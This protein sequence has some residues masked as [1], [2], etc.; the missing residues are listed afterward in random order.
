VRASRPLPCLLSAALVSLVLGAWPSPVY[1]Q[2]A[3]QGLSA[4][5]P[6]DAQAPFRQ[7]VRLDVLD[8]LGGPMDP[9]PIATTTRET[10][11]VPPDETDRFRPAVEAALEALS[12]HA[13]TQLQTFEHDVF[14]ELSQQ[15]GL[16]RSLLGTGQS[17]ALPAAWDL[18]AGR[19]FVVTLPL[20]SHVDTSCASPGNTCR[21]AFET[22]REVLRIARL[23]RVGLE[24][25]ETLVMRQHL[26]ETDRRATSWDEYFSTARSQYLWELLLNGAVMGDSRQE[27]GGVRRG[28]RSVP[29]GQWLLLHPNVAFEYAEA[30]PDGDRFAG[31]VLLDLV[32]YNRWRWN[33]DGSM[34]FALGA[35]LIVAASD[36]AVHNDVGWGVMVHLNHR[37]SAGVVFGDTPTYVVSGDVAQ[38]WT[39]VSNIRRRRMMTGN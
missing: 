36:H 27:V 17:P 25:S 23:A 9:T 22:V 11:D 20:Q 38:L 18:D 35:S 26:L 33:R 31:T 3:N 32:G 39:R 28:F 13:A 24:T 7:L 4:V 16:T 15:L 21:A 5:D 30:E 14:R 1:A 37:W 6:W 19:L 12:A 2:C 29:H 10:L 34:G 8:C